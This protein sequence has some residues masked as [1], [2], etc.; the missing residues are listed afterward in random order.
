[1]SPLIGLFHVLEVLVTA[2][3]QQKEIKQLY[4][5]SWAP[6]NW[7]F[8]TVVLE[9]TPESPLV[10]KEIKSVNPKG[11]QPWIFTGRTDA[12]AEAPIN[13][14]SDVKSQF[15]G[16]ALDAGKD[17]RWEEKGWQRMRWLDGITD[18]MD[19]SLTKLVK[20]TETWSPWGCKESDTTYRLNNSS[21]NSNKVLYRLRSL[22][23]DSLKICEL[24]FSFKALIF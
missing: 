6:K 10:C 9:K 19:M 21:N 18:S 15:T 8:W 5:E 7:C 14:P 11:N 2:V 16:K 12:E 24:D 13:W 20:D 22:C 23:H 3:R 17:W 1:M 4:K